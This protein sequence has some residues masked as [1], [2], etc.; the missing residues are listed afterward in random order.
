MAHAHGNS[1]LPLASD[2]S[3]TTQHDHREVAVERV[4][5]PLLATMPQLSDLEHQTI[6]NETSLT[7]KIDA[8]EQQITDLQMGQS[9]IE[10]RVLALE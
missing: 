6:R 8:I 9:T 2:P 7:K 3:A 4:V 1:P 10:A 5:R